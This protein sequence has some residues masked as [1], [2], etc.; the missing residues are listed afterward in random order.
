MNG[1]SQNRSVLAVGS[2]A[3]D[4]IDGPFGLQRDILGG[5]ASFFATAASYFTDRV[6]LVA[7][8]GDDFPEEHVEF[9]A[10]RGIDLTGLQREGGDS[11]HWYGKYSDDLTSRTTL[12]TKLG[13]FADFRPRLADV[14]RDAEFLFL[15]NIEPSLQASV[16]EQVAAPRLIAADT[17]NLWIEHHA[18]ALRRTLGKVDVLLINDEEARQLSGAHNLAL[19]AN[20][21][22]AMGPR[23]VVIKRGDAGAYL[24]HEDG[25]FAVPAL[26]IEEVRDPTG[27]GDSFAGGFM[28]YLAYAGA[29][30]DD[31]VRGAM[32]A[33]S[34]MASY[35]VEQFSLDGLRNLTAE[36]IEERFAAFQA[37]MRC[38][39]IRL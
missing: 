19:A 16:A 31:A 5:S 24:F 38:D 26:P 35:C 14:H 22:R 30:D 8:I 3:L 25:T 18:D 37:L 39:H 2:V 11:F 20:A 1:R 29:T 28:G 33:G 32:I 9:L 4:D 10:S 17:M 27:A 7:V 34:V 6:A 13:V 21:I 12:D 23:A 36:M 15:G